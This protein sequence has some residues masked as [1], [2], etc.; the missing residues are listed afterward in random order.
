MNVIANY[1]LIP[2]IFFARATQVT[3]PKHILKKC[4]HNECGHELKCPINGI[5]L[6]I[7]FVIFHK[8]EYPIYVLP[9]MMVNQR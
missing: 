1:K 5:H 3:Y 2:K 8:A 9:K 6:K 7:S 4:K